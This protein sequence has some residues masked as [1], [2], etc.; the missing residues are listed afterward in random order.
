ME[1]I[2]NEIKICYDIGER[3]KGMKIFDKLC[4]DYDINLNNEIYIE[5]THISFIIKI[6]EMI[7]II[8]FYVDGYKDI[9]FK[10]SEYLLLNKLQ[11]INKNMVHTNLIFYIEKLENTE[12]ININKNDLIDIDNN[13]GDLINSKNINTYDI[14]NPSILKTA[15]GYIVSIRLTNFYHVGVLNNWSLNGDDNIVNSIIIIVHYDKLFN[16]LSVNNIIDKSWIDENKNGIMGFEDAILFNINGQYYFTCVT[17]NT[18]PYNIGKQTL[19]KLPNISYNNIY[20]IKKSIIIQGT[21]INRVEKN[22]LY[23]NSE[24]N[25][26]MRFIYEHDPL[27][28]IEVEVE[29]KNIEYDKYKNIKIISKNETILDF[30]KFRGS[31]IPILFDFINTKYL[32]IIHEVIFKNNI[33][34]CYIHRFIL[35]DIDYNI[36][37]I[38]KPFYFDNKGVEFCRGLSLNHENNKI[39][40]TIGIDDK[41][42]RIYFIKNEYVLNMLININNLL[43]HII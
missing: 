18:K 15:Y 25:E 42:S 3:E 12:Y 11:S 33:K 36:E 1:S 41:I 37:K 21:N 8:S 20:E 27:T 34:I 17:L 22:W 7:S 23:I 43:I 16:I 2:Y 28:I 38:S 32:S 30:T 9:G 29:N 31:S 19:C 14:C 5:K 26:N 6:F 35:Y 4:K 24:N 40:I 10:I 39:I 13:Y